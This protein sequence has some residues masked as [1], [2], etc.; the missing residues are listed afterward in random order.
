[1]LDVTPV[2][3]VTPLRVGTGVVLVSSRFAGAV[4]VST[5]VLVTVV[6]VVVPA[7]A[8]LLVP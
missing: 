7:A 2:L 3:A 4:V 5:T 8:A 6:V 1:V